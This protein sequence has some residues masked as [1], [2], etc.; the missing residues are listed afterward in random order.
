[1][2]IRGVL[3]IAPPLYG[4]GPFVGS[5][6]GSQ[7]SFTV[8]STTPNPCNCVSLVFTGKLSHGTMRGTYVGNTKGGSETGRWEASRH[9]TFN[10]K[11]QARTNHRYVTTEVTFPGTAFRGLLRARA[12]AIGSWQRFR[13][14]AIGTNQW[15]LNSRANHKYVTAEITYPGTLRGLLRASSNTIGISEEFTFRPVAACACFAL[16]AANAKFVTVDPSTSSSTRGLLR[17]HGTSIGT[18][19][20]FDIT[21]S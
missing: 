2:T 1:M 16:Q 5:V 6:S 3:N 13:C 20:E 21:S 17:A 8:T 9:A 14:V 7:V 11:L 19:Q 10:C 12:S 15:A 4:G 18:R